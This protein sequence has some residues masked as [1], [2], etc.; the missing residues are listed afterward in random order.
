IVK[1]GTE[2]ERERPIAFTKFRQVTTGIQEGRDLKGSER[3]PRAEL[4]GSERS[5]RAELA[6]LTTEERLIIERVWR[7]EEEFEK[8]TKNVCTGGSSLMFRQ[9]SSADQET[10]RICRKAIGGDEQSHRCDECRQA[11]CEDCA[12]YS[13]GSKSAHQQWK[14][15]FCRR[16]SQGQDRSGL[17]PPPGAGMHRVPSVRRMTQ[18]MR[19]LG[20]EGSVLVPEQSVDREEKIG[21]KGGPTKSLEKRRSGSFADEP[22]RSFSLDDPDQRREKNHAHKTRICRDS[23]PPVERQKST[24]CPR[25]SL[26]VRRGNRSGTRGSFPERKI[27]S[28]SGEGHLSLDRKTSFDDQ[29]GTKGNQSSHGSYT[30]AVTG[31]HHQKDLFQQHTSLDSESSV[32][33]FIHE[34]VEEKRRRNRIR[35][36]L[37]IQRQKFYVE[38]PDSDSTISRA[39]LQTRGDA[40]HRTLGGSVETL[41]KWRWHATAQTADKSSPA[42]T[43]GQHSSDSSDLGDVSGEISPLSDR[44]GR[45]ERYDSCYF[46]ERL[47]IKSHIK[48]QKSRMHTTVFDKDRSGTLDSSPSP[49]EHEMGHSQTDKSVSLEDQEVFT[50]PTV[51]LRRS[52]PSVF[53]DTVADVVPS[54][55]LYPP[56][57]EPHRRH[58]TGRALPRVP[59]PENQLGVEPVERHSTHSLDLPRDE[60]C[61]PERRAS[62]PERENIKIVVDQVDDK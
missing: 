33:E 43:F 16:R 22:E 38:E 1:T 5:P 46:S 36:R 27:I 59:V 15:S 21:L 37:R 42:A 3:S 13:K 60:T 11:V 58:S 61:K 19:H 18:K 44:S 30:D 52:I 41:D 2:E 62:A 29:R 25:E 23:R 26:K 45:G 4:E 10:C 39:E 49:D 9:T 28:H 8:E 24:E 54:T 17:E 7:K 35:K 55:R 31:H 32:D 6:R 40:S 56:N 50:Y 20:R 53:V 34:E 14:C 12:S 57:E 48:L 47:G 51:A